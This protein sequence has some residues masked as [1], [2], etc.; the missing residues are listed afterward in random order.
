MLLIESY[1]T[2]VHSYDNFLE[3]NFDGTQNSISPLAQI[4]LSGKLGNKVYNFTEMLKQPD[5]VHF[6]AAMFK[7]VK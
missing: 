1:N 5:K 3:L 6:E 4:Y 7:E 2:L